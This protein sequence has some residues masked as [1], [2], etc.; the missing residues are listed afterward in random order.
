MRYEVFNGQNHALDCQE[1][2]TF[3]VEDI[4]MLF[5]QRIP[6]EDIQ[7]LSDLRGEVGQVKADLDV[8]QISGIHSMKHAVN[9]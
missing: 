1:E 2:T 9:Y 6:V 7:Y 5:Q 8:M 4:S 3:R